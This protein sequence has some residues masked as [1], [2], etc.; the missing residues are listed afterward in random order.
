MIQL[1]YVTLQMGAL[2]CWELTI[3]CA[4]SFTMYEVRHHSITNGIHMWQVENTYSQNYFNTSCLWVVKFENVSSTPQRF[5]FRLIVHTPQR[6]QYGFRP[7]CSSGSHNYWV[8]LAVFESRVG[9]ALRRFSS[10]PT[11]Q[12]TVIVY[13]YNIPA[14]LDFIIILTMSGVTRVANFVVT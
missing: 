4:L 7:C 9:K 5:F 3:E 11:V 13:P 8:F 12:H 2:L 6:L 14:N 1:R 10:Y